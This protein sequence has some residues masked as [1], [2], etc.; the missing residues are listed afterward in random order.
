MRVDRDDSRKKR[1]T[2]TAGGHTHV[3]TFDPSM[4]PILELCHDT[5]IARC[6]ELIGTALALQTFTAKFFANGGRLNGVLKS[7]GP[8]KQETAD[9]LRTFWD[10][11]F[12]KPGN[13]HKIAVL[14]NGLSQKSRTQS[15]AKLAYCQ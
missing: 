12:G 3:W 1:W 4:P 11:T 7:V 15:F 8:I 2:Y 13:A 9:R 14:D 6:R 5:P 10:A